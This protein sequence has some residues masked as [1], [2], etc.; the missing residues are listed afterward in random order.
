MSLRDVFLL[1]NLL[2][3]E[4]HHTLESEH[5]DFWANSLVCEEVAEITSAMDVLRCFGFHFRCSFM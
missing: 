4:R 2:K 5:F 3:L 1:Q